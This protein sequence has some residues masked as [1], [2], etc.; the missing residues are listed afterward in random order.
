MDDRGDPV[1]AAHHARILEIVRDN[2]HFGQCVVPPASVQQQLP[3]GALGLNQPHHAAGAV[4]QLARPLGGGKR[5]RVAIEIAKG[6]RL[7]DLQ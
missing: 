5:L 3:E 7:V 6:D 2:V 1:V 4:G